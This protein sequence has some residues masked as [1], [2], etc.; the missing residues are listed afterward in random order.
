VLCEAGADIVWAARHM[1]GD[2]R[3]HGGVLGDGD[4]TLMLRA[5][6]AVLPVAVVVPRIEGMWRQALGQIA[7]DMGRMVSVRE[8]D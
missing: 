5:L 4:M 3:V 7:R 1:A 8:S 2:L 6:L